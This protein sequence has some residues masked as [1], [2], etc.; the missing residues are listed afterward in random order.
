MPFL[1][2]VVAMGILLWSQWSNRTE[3]ALVAGIIESMVDQICSGGAPTQGIRWADSI[4]RDSV[5]KSI[6]QACSS[7][8]G[9]WSAAVI[10]DA[11]AEGLLEVRINTDSRTAMTLRVERLASGDLLVRGWSSE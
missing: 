9:S 11:S 4:V 10:D 2:V 5:V 6:E 7:S 3:K 1:I 8:K